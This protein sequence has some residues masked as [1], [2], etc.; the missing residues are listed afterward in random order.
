M[1]GPL[2]LTQ[3]NNIKP[4]SPDIHFS[5]DSEDDPRSSYRNNK[6]QKQF[7]MYRADLDTQ[8][9]TQRLHVDKN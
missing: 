3:Y 7:F 2:K 4:E 9:I 8:T 1:T 6:D 5:L